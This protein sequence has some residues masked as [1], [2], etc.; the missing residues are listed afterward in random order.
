MSFWP[1]SILESSRIRV[2][3][4]SRLIHTTD[5]GLYCEAGD[6]Y[7]DPWRPVERAIVTHAHSDHARWGSS[8][9]LCSKPGANVLRHRI[10][11]DAQIESIAYGEKITLNNTTVS[12]HPAGHILGS[13]QIRV[14]RDGEIWVVSGDYKLD[15]D[16]TCQ[17]YEPVK[18]HTFI[19]ES[20]FG[21]PIYT[22]QT[23]DE[24]FT[25][26]NA[27]W[28]K[29]KR[30]GKTSLLLAYALGKAQ[31]L[32]M[33]VDTSIGPIYTHGAI[34]SL[35]QVYL[36]SGVA[37]PETK[38]LSSM[39]R[40]SKF[41][42]ALVLAPPSAYGTPWQRQLNPVSA[43]FAS[44]WMRVRG[45][46]R[47]RSLDKG[48]PVSDHCDWPSLLKAVHLSGAENVL[49]THGYSQILVRYL[50]E[51]GLNADTLS[52]QYEGEEETSSGENSSAD[53]VSEP[54]ADEAPE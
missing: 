14:E 38:R 26:I 21:L 46:R 31:R 28:E 23:N 2:K 13:S 10:G 48:F 45:I 27:W 42:G 18:C 3:M 15:P 9:Y 37:L 6:F 33:G 12:L 8:K 53:S 1:A 50:Q 20:T 36:Q 54:A 24:L 32:L 22:W 34:E 49:V 4:A 39:P 7:I 5:K 41:A 16:P 29:N 51:Q 11:A 40:G 47:R 25:D 17:P 52:T 30:D 19:T 44:G 43:A 35:N